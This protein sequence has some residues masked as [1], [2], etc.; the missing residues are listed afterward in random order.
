MEERNAEMI[1]E[2]PYSAAQ[3]R[4]LQ[5]EDRRR[6]AETPRFPDDKASTQTPEIERVAS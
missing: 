2:G 1:F 4:R 3:D 6:A 5:I